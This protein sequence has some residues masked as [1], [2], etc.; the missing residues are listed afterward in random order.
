MSRQK[1]NMREHLRNARRDYKIVNA[2]LKKKALMHYT[3]YMETGDEA[4][5]LLANNFA[6][7]F[8]V[9]NGK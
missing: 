7:L 4:H 5:L 9:H 3:N 8:R 6:N 2:D 1:F